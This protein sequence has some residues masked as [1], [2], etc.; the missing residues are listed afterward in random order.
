MQY[1]FYVYYLKDK[2]CIK[3]NQNEFIGARKEDKE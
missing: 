1:P 2:L 3:G